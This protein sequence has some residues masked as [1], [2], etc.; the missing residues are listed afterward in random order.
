MATKPEPMSFDEARD[1]LPLFAV[2]QKVRTWYMGLAGPDEKPCRNGDPAKPLRYTDNTIEGVRLKPHGFEEYDEETGATRIVTE[3]PNGWEYLAIAPDGTEDGWFSEAE[4][5][6]KGYTPAP[7]IYEE[8]GRALAL[9][10]VWME[11]YPG[12]SADQHADYETVRKTIEKLKAL[13]PMAASK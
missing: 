5:L 9:A 12:D 1:R 6:A 7:S 4:L 2:G 11:P 13:R 10:W 8:M 3:Y